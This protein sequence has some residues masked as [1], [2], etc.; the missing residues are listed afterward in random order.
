M[1][2]MFEALENFKEIRERDYYVDKSML[3]ED[4]LKSKV[5]LYARP[6]RFGKTLNMSMLYYFFS[7]DEKENNYLFNGL[8]VCS[9]KEIMKHLNQYPVITI[10]LKDLRFNNMD[11]QV[12]FYAS[13]IS[14]IVSD[15]VY[16]YECKDLREKDLKL[17]KQYEDMESSTPHLIKALYNLTKWFYLYYHKKTIIIIDEY[18]VPINYSRNKYYEEMCSFISGIFSTAFKTNQ[19]LERGI[20]TGCLRIAKESIFT[21]LNNPKVN[22]LLDYEASDCFGFTQEELEVFLRYYHLEDKKEIIKDW[23]DGYLFGNTKIYNPWSV[24][25]Y[26]DQLQY[27][28]SLEPDSYWLNTSGNDI[29]YNYLY[30]G[31][32]SLKDDFMTL[33]SGR[34]ITKKIKP[35][36][37]F[38]D[39]DI[40][41]YNNED[42][43]S[44]LLFS[45]Y[46]KVESPIFDSNHKKIRNTYNLIIPNKEIL[47]IYV[48]VF[49]QWFEKE[50]PHSL[51]IEALL[52]GDVSKAQE[53]LEYTLLSSFSFYYS[54]EEVYEAFLLG[55]LSDRGYKV[56]SEKESGFGRYDLFV[57]NVRAHPALIIE[58]K[59]SESIDSLE[60]DAKEGL[61]Q[62]RERKYIEGKESEG[63]SKIL[64]YS[65]AFHRKRCLILKL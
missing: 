3:I 20:I 59:H 10:T 57:Y 44:Y 42:I 24:L 39:L 65:I 60:K 34:S 5:T 31:N 11:D 49:S 63:Y 14:D 18:D 2:V 16:L 27:N 7:I 61:R 62:I 22:T 56:D 4:V 53:I 15:H 33:I 40:N 9:N 47:T 29:I 30:K 13:I 64:G 32:D 37:T 52:K 26:C 19:Y 6:R 1:K 51:F 12:E 28:P 41:D 43:Y 36:L 54:V 17:L 35:Q 38:N 45:G 46:L 8:K 55:Y 21:G 58:C 50:Y 48:E 25:Y 23:Y